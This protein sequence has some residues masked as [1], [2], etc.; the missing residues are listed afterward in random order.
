MSDYPEH[1]ITDEV[2]AELERRYAS[3]QPRPCRICG[4]PL[5]MVDSGASWRGVGAKY[6][7]TSP[8]ADAVNSAPGSYDRALAHYQGSRTDAPSLTG[9]ARVLALVAEVRR[10]RAT[11]ERKIAALG[12]R[13]VQGRDWPAHPE[14]AFTTDGDTLWLECFADDPDAERGQIIG[15]AEP[16]TKWF[17][18]AAEVDQHIIEHGC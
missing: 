6:A 12:S 7:C 4:A 15:I 18:L 2:L 1:Q 5:K 17:E 16:G 8:E 11:A 14:I 13:S 10:L 9:D 3:W